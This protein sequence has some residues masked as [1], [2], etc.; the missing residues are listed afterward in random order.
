MEL[1]DLFVSYKQVDPVEYEFMKP[2]L[3]GMIY[4]NFDRAQQAAAKDQSSVDEESTVHNQVETSSKKENA[5]TVR[6]WVVTNYKEEDT[7]VA[8]VP[9]QPQPTQVQPNP[10]TAT[11]PITTPKPPTTPNA[12]NNSRISKRWNSIYKN[13]RKQWVRDMTAAYKRA[14]LNDNAIKNL[15][16]KNALESGWGENAQGD[17]NFGNITTGKQ[18]KGRY[19][20]GR[21][22]NAAGERIQ[23]KFR[24]YDSLDQ[25]IQNEIQFLRNLYDFNPN[26]DFETFIGKLQGNNK[27]KRRY[28]D[29]TKYSEKVR[30]VYR[31]L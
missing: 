5:P 27:G 19:V 16:A 11:N 20:I 22:R 31:G 8:Q 4:I 10:V 12:I 2:E 25:Y 23:Q 3:P 30:N 17:F 7:P 15:L 29:D 1:K 18:W 6:D 26:D 14:G 13:K 9:K 21:D 28:A 24:A